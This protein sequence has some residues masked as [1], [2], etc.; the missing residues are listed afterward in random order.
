MNRTIDAFRAIRGFEAI[1]SVGS[2]LVLVLAL[3]WCRL[4]AVQ[5]WPQESPEPHYINI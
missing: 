1:A 4:V 5:L 2:V 3:A